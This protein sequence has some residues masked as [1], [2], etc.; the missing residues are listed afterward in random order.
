MRSVRYQTGKYSDVV[1][2]DGRKILA[3]IIRTTD[4]TDELHAAKNA[5]KNGTTMM[6]EL[7]RFSIVSYEIVDESPIIV[8]ANHPSDEQVTRSKTITID[9]VKGFP[10]WDRW[11]T[12]ARNLVVAAWRK[13]STIDD[14]ALADFFASATDV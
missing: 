9:H 3:F 10:G 1:D 13:I 11:S 5:E 2:H 14:E 12:K 7:I 4:G 6:E 8:D